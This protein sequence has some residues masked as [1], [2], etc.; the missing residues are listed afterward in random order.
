MDFEKLKAPFPSDKISW[1]VGSTNK[2]KTKGLAL[3]YID[4]RDVM[5]RLDA[6]CSPENWQNNHPHANGKT[7]CAIGIKIN[8]EWVWKE[9][10]AGDT[11]VEAEKGAFSDAFK[12][13]G[14]MWGIGRYLYDFPETWADIEPYGKSHRIVKSEYARLRKIHEDFISGKN[15]NRS[16]K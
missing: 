4:P 6:V 11:Q 15:W 3:A 7:S 8:N 10:G 1:R 16:P 12:R 13:S 2:D 9:N 14:V 5:D